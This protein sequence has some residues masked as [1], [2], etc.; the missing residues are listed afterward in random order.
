MKRD[1]LAVRPPI[2]L[3][4]WLWLAAL[5]AFLVDG[6]MTLALARTGGGWKLAG[7]A[8]VGALALGALDPQ[9][10]ARAADGNEPWRPALDTSLGYV[11]TGDATIDAA[12]KAGMESLTAEVVRRTAAELADPVAL[13]PAKDELA[14]YPM[15]Y[16]PVAAG[17]PQ[18][19]SGAGARIAAYMRDGGTIVFDTRDALTARDGGPPTPEALWLRKLLDGVDVPEL[20]PLPRDHVATKT[21]YLIDNFIGRTDN[22]QTWIEAL[23]PIDPADKAKRPVRAGDGVSPIILVSNDLAAAWAS[24]DNGHPLYPLI[25]GGP[26]QREFAIRGGINLVLYTLTGNYKADQVHAKDLIERLSH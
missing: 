4:P 1:G 16:W 13:D 23:P 19:G 9:A 15:I 5:I 10:S 11:L 18:P 20:E 24:D 22:G 25:P 14:Y 3:A 12:T 7:L 8:L 17:R 26:R 2:A 21:F 6:A